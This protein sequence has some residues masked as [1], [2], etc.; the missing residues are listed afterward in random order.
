MALGKEIEIPTFQFN[1]AKTI[2][3]KM[4]PQEYDNFPLV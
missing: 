3:A 2:F 1:S 4:Q